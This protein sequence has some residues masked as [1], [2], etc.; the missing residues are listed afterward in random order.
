L[1]PKLVAALSVVVLIA[2]GA[3]LIH[4]GRTQAR[5]SDFPDGMHW[6][7][8]ECQHGFSIPRKEFAAWAAEHDERLPCPECGKPTTAVAQRC[9]LSDCGK[10][11]SSPNL[12]L[13][14]V[15]S[16]PVCREPLP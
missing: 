3:Q 12:V 13:D 7:C 6:L 16:C 11:Y 5:S 15:V 4:F 14:G 8:V 10:Y 2:A 9:P 1:K